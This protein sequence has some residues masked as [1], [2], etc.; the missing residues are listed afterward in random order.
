MDL[1]AFHQLS[2]EHRVHLEYRT[3]FIETTVIHK[4][5]RIPVDGLSSTQF[6][7]M[8]GYFFV[9]QRK[10]AG[11]PIANVTIDET[12]VQEKNQNLMKNYEN[13]KN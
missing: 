1:V 6:T 4:F 9:N 13:K 2:D 10:N 7:I 12:L 5:L 3:N 8:D 11:T